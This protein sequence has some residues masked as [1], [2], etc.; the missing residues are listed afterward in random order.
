MARMKQSESIRREAA[1]LRVSAGRLDALADMLDGVVSLSV[2]EVEAATEP[3]WMTI[4]RAEVGVHEIAGA[5]DNARIVEYHKATTLKASDDETPWCA[6]FVCWCLA[7]AGIENPRSAASKAFR[8]WGVQVQEPQVGD[9]VVFDHGG[10]KGHVGFFVG[11]EG[12]SLRILG[13]NQGDAVKVATFTRKRLH[14]FRR[15]PVKTR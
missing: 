3:P 15:P 13:G 14:S 9:V 12:T 10:G 1:A 7:Q 4:A 5:E 6:S 2:A 11:G 8:T